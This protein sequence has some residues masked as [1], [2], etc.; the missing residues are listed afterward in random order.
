M[1]FGTVDLVY[2]KGDEVLCRQDGVCALSIIVD[3]MKNMDEETRAENSD[4]T[5]WVLEDGS[6][7]VHGEDTIGL[8]LNIAVNV[9]S[10]L[11]R[12]RWTERSEE[13]YITAKK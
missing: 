10:D 2:K 6:K 11:F 13:Y 3:P 7:Y 12:F 4:I 1:L 9:I 8:R 5:E